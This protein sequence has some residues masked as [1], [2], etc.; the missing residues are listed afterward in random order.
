MFARDRALAR[1]ASALLV[2]ALI[3]QVGQAWSLWPAGRAGDTPTAAAPRA[4]P[5]APA[6][7]SPGKA[8][9][10]DYALFGR[11]PHAADGGGSAP[12]PPTSLGLVLRGVLALGGGRGYALIDSGTGA[13]GSGAHRS[14]SASGQAGRDD[15]LFAV[16]DKVVGQVRLSEVFHDHVILRTRHGLESLM[17]DGEKPPAAHPTAPAPPASGPDARK[18]VLDAAQSKR[19]VQ[20]L[21]DPMHFRR[22]VRARPV[23]RNNRLVGY[24]VSPAGDPRLFSALGLHSGDI[25]TRV[26]G[27]PLDGGAL[28]TFELLTS[29]HGAHAI[30][31][32]VQ[33]NGREIPLHVLLQ[34]Q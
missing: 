2:A 17:L 10:L 16:G 24:V 11:V 32:H 20:L 12:P 13:A 26:N 31:L 23:R 27:T 3:W 18:K 14:S 30:N 34:G 8:E 4:R 33:R 7:A 21:N 22:Y 15:G 19:V 5:A 28:N 9:G 25:I 29:V 1:L 6:A